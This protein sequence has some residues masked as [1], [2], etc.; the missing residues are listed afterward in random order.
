MLYD[1]QTLELN[2]MRGMLEDDFTNTK[3][4]LTNDLKK[5]NQQFDLER[6]DKERKA[7]EDRIRYEAEEAQYLK[8]R[9]AK[10]DFYMDI[11]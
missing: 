10:Q 6:K 3:T 8:E 11:K 9:G 5:T 4:N 1:Q 7:K 2:R